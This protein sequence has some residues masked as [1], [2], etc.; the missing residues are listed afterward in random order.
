M[1]IEL[2]TMCCLLD[3]KSNHVLMI[4]RKKSWKGMAFPGGHLENGESITECIRREMR[5]E[6]GLKIKNLQ[7]KGN[8][9]FY[10]TRSCEKR[11]VWNYFSDDFEGIVKKEC[12]EG[13]LCW[14]NPEQLST[15]SLAE[16]MELRFPLFFDRG[17]FELY[18]EWDEEQG[19]TD[20]RKVK[21]G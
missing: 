12:D 1:D 19:Y 20:I 15:V 3:R 9:L 10:N 14:I 13:E 5:E 18:V 2:T 7:Y 8:V 17:I 21:I 6:T 16:G 11:M 4:K